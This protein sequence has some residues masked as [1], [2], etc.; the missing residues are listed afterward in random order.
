MLVALLLAYYVTL[1][2]MVSRPAVLKLEEGTRDGHLL[3]FYLPLQQKDDKF[4][5]VFAFI[6]LGLLEV[7]MGIPPLHP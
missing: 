4:L 3:Q 2:V 6:K 5:V 1:L 7:S